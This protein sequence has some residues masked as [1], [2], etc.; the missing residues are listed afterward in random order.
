M[1]STRL[2]TPEQLARRRA[3]Q[4]A[5]R[6][7]MTPEQR[8]RR[9]AAQA[10]WRQSHQQHRQT[11]LR[12]WRRRQPAQYWRRWPGWKPKTGQGRWP[13]PGRTP[14]QI[15]EANKQKHRRDIADLSDTYLRG[16]M[17]RTSRRHGY[18]I[19]PSAWPAALVEAKRAQ[20]KV[21]RL[22]R[23]QTPSPN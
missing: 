8:A 21:I 10:R 3:T 19:K 17:S 6:Q 4:R 20:M 5:Y 22:C 9:R 23:N 15:R 18:H 7:R 14:D 12:E 11:Y 2:I 1:P 13:T 16:W